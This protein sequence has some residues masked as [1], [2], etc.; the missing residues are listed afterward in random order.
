ML[1]DIV[2][3]HGNDV[4]ALAELDLENHQIF[5]AECGFG[6]CKVE[7]PRAAE[8]FVVKCSLLPENVRPPPSA[9]GGAMQAYLA[10]ITN[11]VV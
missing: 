7:F 4:V 11:S 10:F 9:G 2:P 8:A 1:A 3:R 6:A 5:V